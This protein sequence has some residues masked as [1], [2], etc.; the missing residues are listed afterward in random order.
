MDYSAQD[1]KPALDPA[2]AAPPR[3]APKLAARASSSVPRA[4]GAIAPRGVRPRGHEDTAGKME[5]DQTEPNPSGA[6]PE[7]NAW[8]S[9]EACGGAQPGRG[10]RD[11]WRAMSSAWRGVPAARWIAPSAP[12]GDKHVSHP[13]WSPEPVREEPLHSRS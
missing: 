13:G 12:T 2:L 7:A 9:P 11:S 8:Q 1:G 6:T 4:V 3:R 5:R 10:A